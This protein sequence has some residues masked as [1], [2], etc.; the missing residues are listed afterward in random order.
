MEMPITSAADIIFF[1]FPE[2]ISLTFHVN[3]AIRMKS[4]ALFSLEKKKKNRMTS[5]TILLVALKLKV[6]MISLELYP[7][8]HVLKLN[9]SWIA[10][11]S[12]IKYCNELIISCCF[13]L[14]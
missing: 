2:E 7:F 9:M 11:S 3:L 10:M 6:K 4:E 13:P 14:L 5:A 8:I 1:F 12:G